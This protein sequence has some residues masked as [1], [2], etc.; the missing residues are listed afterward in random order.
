M[1]IYARSLKILALLA[2]LTVTA[3]PGACAGDPGPS[4]SFARQPE[5]APGEPLL[6]SLRIARVNRDWKGVARW[7]S[8]ARQRRLIARLPS[9]R[10]EVPPR[11]GHVIAGRRPP[12]GR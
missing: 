10:R 1:G 7:K 5:R 3:F 12:W 4:D 11:A 6:L 2:A 9:G 8:L